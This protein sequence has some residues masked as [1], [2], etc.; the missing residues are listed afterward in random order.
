MAFMLFALLT[1]IQQAQAPG[2]SPIWTPE[3][4][5][6]G[7]GFA[8]IT[9]LVSMVG[10]LAKMILVRIDEFITKQNTCRET[11]PERFA[12]KDGTA[13][14]FRDLFSRTD[15]HERMLERHSVMLGGRREDDG[16]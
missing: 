16:K 6:I 7:I 4:V 3:G 9:V 2:A 14:K 13:E 10:Y 1:A 12:D 5:L 11:L 8:V 15:R